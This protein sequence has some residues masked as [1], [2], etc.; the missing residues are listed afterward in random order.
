MPVVPE[1]TPTEFCER[2]QDR[3]SSVVLLDVREHAELEIAAVAGARHIPM[4]EIPG[5]L[6]ELDR[7]TPLVVM[8]HSGGRSRRVADYLQSNGFENVFNLRGGIDAWSTEID[9]Q[10]PR[11]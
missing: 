2:W 1:L 3:E 4:G 5:R 7:N 11:Y 9:P 10:V 6:A 8:C